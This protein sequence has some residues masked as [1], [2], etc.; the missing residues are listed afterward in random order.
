[1]FKLMLFQSVLLLLLKFHKLDIIKNGIR[2]KNNFVHFI[3]S[4][5]RVVILLYKKWRVTYRRIYQEIMR[6]KRGKI[7][8]QV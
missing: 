4:D 8:L 5:L 2:K 3:K 7:S 6:F 1:M